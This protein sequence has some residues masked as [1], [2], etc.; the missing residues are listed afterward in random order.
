MVLKDYGYFLINPMR[1]D[2]KGGDYVSGRSPSIGLPAIGLH[3]TP[4]G[5]EHLASTSRYR[6]TLRG[7][8]VRW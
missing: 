6:C 2:S 4:W 3:S 8:R 1:G 7:I 5:L